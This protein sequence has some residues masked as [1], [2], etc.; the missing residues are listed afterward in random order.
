MIMKSN[1]DLNQEIKS[2]SSE[3]MVREREEKKYLIIE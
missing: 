1:E 2:N 3:T